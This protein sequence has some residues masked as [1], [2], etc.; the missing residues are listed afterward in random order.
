MYALKPLVYEIFLKTF[1][2]REKRNYCFFF[3]W[4]FIFLTKVVSKLYLNSLLTII[5]KA[6]VNNN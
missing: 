5:L 3:L 1:L 6:P 2:E 4:F